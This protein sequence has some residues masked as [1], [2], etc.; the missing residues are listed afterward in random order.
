VSA[1]LDV[2]APTPFSSPTPFLPPLSPLCVE[3]FDPLCLWCA[4]FKKGCP[5]LRL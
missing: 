1:H 3:E 4:A 5:S 2:P